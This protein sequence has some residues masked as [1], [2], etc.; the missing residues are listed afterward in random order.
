MLSE[1]F[2]Q[3]SSWEISRRNTAILVSVLG[4]MAIRDDQFSR[5]SFKTVADRRD[6]IINAM[7][8]SQKGIKRNFRIPNH[9]STVICLQSLGS[10]LAVP[11][12]PSSQLGRNSPVLQTPAT[13]SP[14]FPTSSFQIEP[15]SSILMGPSVSQSKT[16]PTVVDSAFQPVQREVLCRQQ[17]N[18]DNHD[19]CIELRLG[20]HLGFPVGSGGFHPSF[21]C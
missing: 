3:S 6:T 19:T 2:R 7:L 4:Q 17:T 1:S 21:T 15:S 11:P 5:A 12:G 14:I 20:H 9:H 13:T 18:N 8:L 10:P 16:A